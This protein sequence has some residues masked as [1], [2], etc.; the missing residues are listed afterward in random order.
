MSDCPHQLPGPTPGTVTCRAGR[1]G[2]TP[3]RA[4]C[5][6]CDPNKHTSP[7]LPIPPSVDLPKEDPWSDFLSCLGL[8]GSPE[9]RKL[10]RLHMEQWDR[11]GFSP[12]QRRARQEGLM[13]RYRPGSSR[14]FDCSDCSRHATEP[15]SRD[16]ARQTGPERASGPGEP[17]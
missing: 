15:G 13:E 9:V 10:V 17:Y 8:C 14:V 7:H 6:I 12:C 1:Y 11:S 3:S 5:K 4:V 16:T 2:G